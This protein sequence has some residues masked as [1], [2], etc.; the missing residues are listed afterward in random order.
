MTEKLSI[1]EIVLA[2]GVLLAIYIFFFGLPSYVHCKSV[3][4]G[5]LMYQPALST[6]QKAAGNP[7]A[8]D[9]WVLADEAGSFKRFVYSSPGC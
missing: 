9:F 2:I 5:C 1:R 3:L 4:P 6:K 8:L 7:A